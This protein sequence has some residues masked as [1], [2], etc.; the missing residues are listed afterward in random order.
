MLSTEA[1]LG[2]GTDKLCF[3]GGTS[4][5]EGT[6]QGYVISLGHKMES[7]CVCVC[8][9]TLGWVVEERQRE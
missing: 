3:N 6:C 4:H 9:H 2:F 8:V 5:H 7:D 1:T